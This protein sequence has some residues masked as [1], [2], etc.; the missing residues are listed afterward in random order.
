MESS[1][2]RDEPSEFPVP[3]TADTESFL[4]FPTVSPVLVFDS[5]A[6]G[7]DLNL[8]TELTKVE[9]DMFLF[10]KK[11]DISFLDKTLLGGI[12]NLN[13]EFSALKAKGHS[14]FVSVNG[15]KSP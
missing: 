6:A 7:I 1:L 8:L 9:G 15:T 4:A 2:L 10:L 12:C 14:T 13:G 5:L 3:I 11:L